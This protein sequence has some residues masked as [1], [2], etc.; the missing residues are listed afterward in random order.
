MQNYYSKSVVVMINNS[1]KVITCYI[2]QNLMGK[3]QYSHHM[4]RYKNL[5]FPLK[6]SRYGKNVEKHNSLL[7]GDL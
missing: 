5:I 7:Q 3:K 1:I 6:Y 2:V 4:R